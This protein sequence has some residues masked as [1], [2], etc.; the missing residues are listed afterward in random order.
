MRK[1]LFF[2]PE[3]SGQELSLGEGAENQNGAEK[4]NK[5]SASENI[6]EIENKYLKLIQ[7]QQEEYSKQLREMEVKLSEIQ[8]K[9]EQ[10]PAEEKD[11]EIDFTSEGEYLHGL[12]KKTAQQIVELNKKIDGL[13]N[14]QS[15]HATDYYQA[16][17]QDAIKKNI[18]N[19]EL[20]NRAPDAW[21]EEISH[22]LVNFIRAKENQGQSVT[23]PELLGKIKA[24]VKQTEKILT[25]NYKI[26]M[27]TTKGLDTPSASFVA[28]NKPKTWGSLE[29]ASKALKETL[30]KIT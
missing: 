25:T 23:L 29:E 30:G 3:E 12:F 8:G 4:K 13:Q 18:K 10:K 21:E 19:S 22:Y 17:I 20:L 24:K 28:Q 14:V 16:T 9:T 6:A 1:Q 7:E 5:L 11:T 26:D 2:S 15:K 27:I